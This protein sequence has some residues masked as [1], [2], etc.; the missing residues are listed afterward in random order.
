MTECIEIFG[1]HLPVIATLAGMYYLFFTYATD[2]N[3]EFVLN[4][5]KGM[6]IPQ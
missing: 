3:I 1:F 4:N 5:T 6:Y 2:D